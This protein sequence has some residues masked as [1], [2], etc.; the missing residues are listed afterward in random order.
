MRR[1]CAAQPLLPTG[2]TA[3][4]TAE[5][6][7]NQPPRPR[8]PRR[9]S[10]A[11]RISKRLAIALSGAALALALA[12]LAGAFA[13]AAK[14]ADRAAAAPPGPAAAGPWP[15]RPTGAVHG[16][17][18]TV[19]VATS[20]RGASVPANFLG[21]SFETASLP[22]LAAYGH[23]G[24]LARILRQL[25]PGV[26]RIGGLSAD[27]LAA[28]VPE[29]GR[30]PAW[31]QVAVNRGELA[32][33]GALAQGSDWQ[34]ILTANT[35][36]YNPQAAAQEAQAA[37]AL[38][39]GR[40]LAISIGNEPDRYV[41][42]GLLAP[43]WSFAGYAKRYAAYRAAIDAAAPGVAL[44]APD[45]SS[46][47]SVLPWV[48]AAVTLHPT[49]LTDHFYPLTAC[50]EE[51][52]TI[53]ELLS[54]RVAQ[55][56]RT[57]L[58]QLHAISTG[59]HIPLRIDEA[60]DISCHGEAGVSN[61]FASA[62]WAI[63]FISSAMSAGLAGVNF[64]DLLAEADAYSP[65]VFAAGSYA[66]T[67]ADR[68]AAALGRLL[69]PLPLHANP[70]WYALLMTA[71]LEHSSALGT[72]ASAPPTLYSQAYLA[73]DGTLRVVLDN[74][75]P[76]GSRP[77]AIKLAIEGTRYAEGSIMRLQ[78]SSLSATAGV[79]LG[80]SELSPQGLWRP[81]QPLEAPAQSAGGPMLALPAASAALVTLEPRTLK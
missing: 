2:A 62:L 35:A 43:G 53:E 49:L 17:P 69:G 12:L 37:A 58:A 32:D 7:D 67:Q 29:G 81:A 79:R 28:W 5:L 4:M 74:T 38:L 26:L 30:L 56:E 40:L 23:G 61:S 51:H 21:L 47:L 54:A 13:G 48:R 63:R 16:L 18:V 77:L 22:Y 80:G 75:A 10:R 78:A 41:R 24:T 60:N 57:L 6:R 44:A 42:E 25:G 72:T 45:A 70:E 1:A 64:H 33:L 27:K 8:R 14:R 52:P 55:Q 39:H 36:H 15:T 46:G 20:A 65:L 50:A 31:A 66:P 9:G 19:V 3:E 34:A 59:A 71:P 11:R 76:A 68:Q 73:P